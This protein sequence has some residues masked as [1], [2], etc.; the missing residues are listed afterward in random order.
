MSS[1]WLS[2]RFSL[3]GERDTGYGSNGSTHLDAGGYGDNGRFVLVLPDGRVMGVGGGR[4]ASAPIPTGATQP[5]T[6]GTVAVA[7]AMPTTA[8]C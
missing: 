7:P 4:A 1:D 5:G 6:D 8:R 2:F 3:N